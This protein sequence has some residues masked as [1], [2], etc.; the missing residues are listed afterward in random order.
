MAFDIV[1]SVTGL[2]VIVIKRFTSLHMNKT[3]F[4]FFH[5]YFPTESNLWNHAKQEVQRLADL[6]V[7][8]VWLPPAYKSAH[9]AS[10]PGYA[11]YD[12]YDL[13]EFDQKG[14]VRTKYGT[15]EEYIN[16]IRDFHEKKLNVLADIVL[17]H[18][19]GGDEREEIPVQQVKEEDRNEK[20][21]E[22]LKVE[23][24]TRFTFPGRNGKYSDYIWDWHSFTGVSEGDGIHLVLN[25]HGNG[26]WEDVM[27]DQHGNYD[28]LMGCDIEYRNPAVR[29]ELKKWGIW[30]VETTGV[31]GFRLDAVKHIST[32]FFPD[33]LNSLQEYFQRDFFTIGEYWK[34][35]KDPLLRYIDATGGMIHLFDVP[36]HFNF[37][38]ASKEG[39]D[40]DLRQI[41]D[42]TL[43]GARP[44]RAITFVDNHDTQPLQSLESWV[45]PWFKPH[46]Y[47]LILLREQGIPCVF[48]TALYGANYSG[49]KDGEEYHI[50]I[51]VTKE[52]ETLINVRAVYA[53]GQQHDYFDDAHMIGWTRA[54]SELFS[55]SGCAV[56]ISNGEGGEKT[57]Y[58]GSEHAG[59]KMFALF[60]EAS[61]ETILNEN[62][63]GVFSVEAGK[64]SVWVFKQ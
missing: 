12:L 50:D 14:T 42:N 40:F 38:R 64:I 16:C 39:I 25:E 36:L 51:P 21:T 30:Y 33:W 59:K 6:G 45:D 5:W 58:V 54:G 41:F 56:L 19:M 57:M 2:S 29:E 13:G 11:V 20:T 4:Q 61:Y 49:S 35:D 28:Y 34:A 26:A 27:E 9:G 62:G 32:E 8:D 31:D 63:E 22:P 47:A 10:E 43:V 37:H 44:D 23:A 17:N 15:K 18:K 60:S 55:G 3:I 53:Y 46:A 24:S 52:L 7:T 48:Y 1:Q